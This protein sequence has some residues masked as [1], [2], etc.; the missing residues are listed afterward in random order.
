MVELPD[1]NSPM[2]IIDKKKLEHARRNPTQVSIHSGLSN[3]FG[4][5]SNMA[6]AMMQIPRRE[7]EV[8]MSNH[9]RR[10]SKSNKKDKKKD[11]KEKHMAKES[12]IENLQNELK[13]PIQILDFTFDGN[14]PVAFHL[15]IQQRMEVTKV[16]EDGQAF[17]L[18]V[19]QGL[20]VIYFY[21]FDY[22]FM[23]AHV[24]VSTL[25]STKCTRKL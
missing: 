23:F 13:L 8:D 19:K 24:H 4:K 22:C 18:G 5:N 16:K 25:G 20:Y 15:N 9:K 12:I 2:V 1:Q 11:K 10:K 3:A 17:Q 7:T 14:K 21:C 6:S